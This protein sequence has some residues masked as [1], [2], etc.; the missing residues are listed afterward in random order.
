MGVG[1]RISFSLKVRS[2][3]RNRN[4]QR[5]TGKEGQEKRKITRI[6]LDIRKNK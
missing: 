1:K 2:K 4:L 3:D 6:I 5:K